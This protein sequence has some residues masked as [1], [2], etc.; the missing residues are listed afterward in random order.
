MIHGEWT[1]ACHDMSQIEELLVM[2]KKHRDAGVTRVSVMYTWL[3]RWIQSQQ[4]CTSFGIEYL[5]VSDPS[6]FSVERIEK[7]EALLRV[8]RVLI[9]AETIPYV[10]SLYSAKNFPKQVGVSS[11]IILSSTSD[12]L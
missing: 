4:K 10:L 11:R 3:G 9:G 12:I 5:G 1:M 8:S 6:Q 7:G 2:I